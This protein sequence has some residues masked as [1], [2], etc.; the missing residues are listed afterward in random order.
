[1]NKGFHYTCATLPLLLIAKLKINEK[2]R[3]KNENLLAREFKK[4][5]PHSLRECSPALS[6][7]WSTIK[8]DKTYYLK[9]IL[10]FLS[11]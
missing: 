11:T 6:A 5:G 1:V 8:K 3:N 4:S 10:T 2:E 7:K 9:Y